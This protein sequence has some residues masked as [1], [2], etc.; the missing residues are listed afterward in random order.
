MLIIQAYDN[1]LF[2]NFWI[3]VRIDYITNKCREVRERERERGKCFVGST[4]NSFTMYLNRERRKESLQKVIAC[5]HMCVSSVW[6]SPPHV[7][8]S[9]KYWLLLSVNSE[10][11]LFRPNS[12]V[13][14]VLSVNYSNV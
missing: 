2:L 12:A 7:S 6:N 8:L 14:S 11:L 4:I 13:F 5:I 10:Y 9:R 1:A 3:Q